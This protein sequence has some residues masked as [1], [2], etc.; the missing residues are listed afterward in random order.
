ML[1]FQSTLSLMLSPTVTVFAVATGT[2]RC[3]SMALDTLDNVE[4][5]LM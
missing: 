3:N 1:P 4:Q 2:Y 5:D